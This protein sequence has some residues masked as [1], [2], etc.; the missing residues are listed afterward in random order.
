MTEGH[1][2]LDLYNITFL[3]QGKKIA[4]AGEQTLKDA[5]T[6]TGIRPLNKLVLQ[7]HD[8]FAVLH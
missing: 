8:D 3:P 2:A 6:E 7:E 5:I 1:K 4:L